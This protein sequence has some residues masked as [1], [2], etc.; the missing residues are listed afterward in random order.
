MTMVV[1]VRNTAWILL[2][3]SAP[4]LAQP[5]TTTSVTGRVRELVCRGNVGLPLRVY[6]NPS[7]RDPSGEYAMMLLEY[8]PAATP[9]GMDY[10]GLKPGECS[11]N[12]LGWKDVPKESGR[13]YFDV[14]REAQPWSALE[15]RAMDTTARAGAFFPDPISL[16]RYL[17]N[18]QHYWRF[19]V[20]DAGSYSASF[21]AWKETGTPTFVT[22]SG[23]IG[24][25]MSPDTRRELRCRGGATGLTFT[26]GTSA[27]TNLVNMTLAYR[28]SAN[29]PGQTGKGLD[30]GSCAWVDR[31]A[32][33][34]EPG[35]VD[36]TTEGNA[37]LKQIQSGG[38]V[39]R[40]ATA[41][42]RYPDA[43]TIPVYLAD[44]TRYWTFTVTV[45]SPNTARTHA[46]WKP[47]I[48]DIITS[49]G[50]TEQPTSIGSPDRSGRLRDASPVLAASK[51]SLIFREVVRK[52]NE[53]VV[54]FSARAGANP[55]VYYGTT[56]P[57]RSTNTGLLGIYGGTRLSTTQTT[58]RGFAAE[59]SSVP[60]RGLP[61]GTKYYFVIIVPEQGSNKPESY[62][63]EF[64]TMTQTVTVRFMQMRILNDS[65][66]SGAGE[67]TFVLNTA[68]APK[69]DAMNCA[70]CVQG[71][72]NRSWDTGNSYPLANM[73]RFDNSTDRLRIWVTGWDVDTDDPF[74]VQFA[75]PSGSQFTGTGGSDSYREWNIARGEFNLAENPDRTSYSKS[76]RLRSIDGFTFMFEVVGEIEVSRQ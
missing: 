1:Q 43:N 40:S 52:P 65:D 45:G 73:F 35:R 3:A 46:A 44:A 37:Q 16:P 10:A 27:G 5:G 24:P 8:V 18:P 75:P 76:F 61:R 15:T 25:A 72:E 49:K 22:V 47:T 32:M 50:P 9:P 48:L 11:W 36:F 42:Q 53:Y 30:P 7:S 63:G 38:T 58:A 4:T 19:F 41:A 62:G 33:A 17:A 20:D 60:M 13:V 23:P 6:E 55:I 68:L 12:M 21:G 70:P 51:A 67:L 29:P 59:Y 31:T 14:K 57:V 54:K 66:K 64:M 2:L 74:Y 56:P 26:R 71:F 69:Y 39:D 28:V 34:R